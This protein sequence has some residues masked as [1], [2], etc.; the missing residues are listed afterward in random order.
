M[1]AALSVLVLA[2]AHGPSAPT[3]VPPMFYSEIVKTAEVIVTGT[4]GPALS[5]HEE[6]GNTIRTY[7]KFDKLTWH[8]GTPAES[9]TLRLEGGRVGEDRLVVREMPEFK[10]GARYLLYVVGNG[11][12]VSPI[13]GFYQ[14]AFEIVN[15]DGREVLVTLKGLE[16]IG[17]ENDR[18]V[19]AGSA[20]EK[21]A[22]GAPE[23]VPVPGFVPRPADP[24]VDA[25]EEE[26]L[27]Q[28]ALAKR[29]DPPLDEAPAP[30]PEPM[31]REGNGPPPH[32]APATIPTGA[33]E[34]HDAQS[35]A[36]KDPTP[37][38]IPAAND[39]G[40]RT[41]AATL[42]ATVPFESRRR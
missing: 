28:R 17:I 39:A 40:W 7:V 35:A 20:G 32:A 37:I 23:L 18:F 5:R 30:R 42:L 4:A 3:V 25:K 16:L 10:P 12:N 19:C 2:A 1:F 24:N 41:D 26:M 13:V 31:P 21:P 36:Q 15:R 27:R 14:G 11:S 29:A 9:L 6:G 38:V 22:T 34:R 33:V 8:K